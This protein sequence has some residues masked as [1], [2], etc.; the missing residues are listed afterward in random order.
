MGS[1]KAAKAVTTIEVLRLFVISRH[2]SAP[3]RL[4]AL[5]D[6]C[7]ERVKSTA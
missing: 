5:R 1:S 7:L 3:V 6:H 2:V 4:Q